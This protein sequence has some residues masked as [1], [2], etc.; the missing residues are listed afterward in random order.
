MVVAKAVLMELAV[1]EPVNHVYEEVLRQ[2]DQ[3]EEHRRHIGVLG[4]L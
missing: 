4:L 1:E 2:V 3:D